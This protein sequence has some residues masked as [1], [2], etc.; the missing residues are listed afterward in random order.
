MPAKVLFKDGNCPKKFWP[1]ELLSKE[2]RIGP[3]VSG[4]GLI[5]NKND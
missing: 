1:E 2:I 4:R 3:G 5:K